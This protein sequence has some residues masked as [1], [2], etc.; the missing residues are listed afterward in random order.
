MTTIS[1]HSWLE[2]QPT[3]RVDLACY[4][5]PPVKK[6]QTTFRVVHSL[7]TATKYR[8]I[9]HTHT[10]YTAAELSSGLSLKKVI[11]HTYLK[12]K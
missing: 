2:D 1:Q 7:P 10:N 12:C 6:R 4:D 3:H 9:A 8:E 5:A 11:L